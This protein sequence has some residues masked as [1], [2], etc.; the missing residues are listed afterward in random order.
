[1]A[2]MDFTEPNVCIG[3]NLTTDSAGLLHMQPF[4]VPRPVRDVKALANDGDGKVFVTTKLPGKLLINQRL[5]WRNDTPLEQDILIRIIRGPREQVVSNPNAIQ[6]RDRWSYAVDGTPSVPVTS[7]YFNSQ[8]G[9]AF[10]LG[11]K[12][13]V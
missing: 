12:G 9:T 10:D 7:G 8:S 13:A 5:D 4:A 11:T 1:M 2:V 3:E 6:F